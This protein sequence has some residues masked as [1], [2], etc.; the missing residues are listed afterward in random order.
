MQTTDSQVPTVSDPSRRNSDLQPN[1]LLTF[2]NNGDDDD[3]D[4]DDDDCDTDG[5]DT[6]YRYVS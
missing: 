2:N 1:S 3:D 5:D 6:G 4:D